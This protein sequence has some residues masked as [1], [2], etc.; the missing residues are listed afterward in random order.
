MRRLNKQQLFGLTAIP[1][2][3]WFIAAA[4]VFY[5]ERVFY[6]DSAAQ[7][8]EMLLSGNLEIYVSRYSMFLNQLLPLGLIKLHA[9]ISIVAIG[10]SVSMPIITATASYLCLFRWKNLEAAFAILFSA[11]LAQHTFFHAISE[12]MLLVPYG[13]M[14]YAACANQL[15]IDR[16]N[17]F[18]YLSVFC[19]L[20]LAFFIHP[21]SIFF[22]SYVFWVLWLRNGRIVIL[23]LWPYALGFVCLFVAKILIG[24]LS[25]ATAHDDSFISQLG[26]NI[27]DI[28]EIGSFASTISFTHLIRP[29]LWPILILFAFSILLGLY[30]KR[31][32]STFGTAGFILVF[33]LITLLIYRAGDS[34]IGMERAFLPLAFLVV[35]GAKEI[36]N[37]RAFVIAP[38]L[39]V[40]LGFNNIHR[41]LPDYSIRIDHMLSWL[42]DTNKLNASKY[43]CQLESDVANEMKVT[44]GTSIETMLLSEVIY[45]KTVTIYC[46]PESVE[47]SLLLSNREAIPYTP[48]NQVLDDAHINSTNYFESHGKL[49]P[50]LPHNIALHFEGKLSQNGLYS[51]QNGMVLS[52]SVDNWEEK[53]LVVETT[54]P[55][56]NVVEFALPAYAAI[57]SRASLSPGGTLVI[58]AGEAGYVQ[59]TNE[60]KEWEDFSIQLKTSDSAV[61]AILYIHNGTDSTVFAKEIS[62]T[63]HVQE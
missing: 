47:K 4:I 1:F 52:K 32:K 15:V 24:K 22:I 25:G 40:F 8:F 55:Y 54:N 11:A 44:W 21:V 53:K 2:F 56:Q 36:I 10:Y 7:L 61:N 37:S 29:M 33:F 18:G 6:I 16:V 59:K 63:I 14:F 39:I 5:K 41:A 20:L 34:L 62:Y 60:T 46:H 28:S 23:K 57:N 13:C 58:D 45:N 43:Y 50:L 9:P 26:V 27:K 38:V 49:Y 17:F 30:R 3:L 35:I 12:T 48:F 31:W 51:S 19:C 42:E